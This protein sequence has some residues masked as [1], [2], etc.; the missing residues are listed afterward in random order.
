MPITQRHRTIRAA[1][2][3][4]AL[5]FDDGPSIYTSQILDTLQQYGGHVSFFVTGSKVEEGKSKIFRAIQMECEVIC[6]AWNHP[7]FTE[8]SRRAIKKEIVNTIIAIA[9]VTGT[10][11]PMFRPPYGHINKR[12][13]RLAKN[14]GLAIINWS[15]SPEDWKIQD[16]ENIYSHIISNLKDGDI[17]LCH[18]VYETTA[19]AMSRLIPE[20]ISRN[21]E[22][23]T[24][25]E[26]L[27][28]KYGKIEPG[29]IYDN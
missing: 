23:V 6:H 18:D 29:R 4:V 16:A 25:T 1:K 7:D 5:T 17:V 14:L 10:A 21:Y 12:V 2:P 15:L 27:T 8:L 13:E 20:L 22:L 3:V 11:S 19:T 26:L 9:K 28:R 24:V